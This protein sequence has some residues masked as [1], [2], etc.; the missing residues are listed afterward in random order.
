MSYD[1]DSGR[2]MIPTLVQHCQRGYE[3]LGEGLREEILLPILTSCTPDTLWRFEEEDPVRGLSVHALS[4]HSGSICTDIWKALCH[5]QHPLLVRDLDE[6]G[7]ESWK[8]EYARCHEESANKLEQAAARLRAK[9]QLD[10]EQ[11]KASSIKITDKVPP[12][13]RARWG[14]TT[15]KTLFQ[16]TRTEAVKH[17]KGVFS[18][19]MT[20]PTFQ[21]RALV[22]NATSAWGAAAHFPLP[23]SNSTSTP[24]AS[25]S[26]VTVRAV[27]VPRKAPDADRAPSALSK[28]AGPS[29]PIPTVSSSSMYAPPTPASV[30]RPPGIPPSQ[31]A[32]IRSPPSRSPRKKD[33]SSALF[34]PKH[35]AYS[36]LQAR[37][38]PSKS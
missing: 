33:P 7:S 32:D 29:K 25:G 23:S 34:M 12:T 30:A 35:R 15:S 18:T 8:E 6:S 38:V 16:K 2:R 21:R 24:A 9:R 14:V 11:R 22:N 5:K 28:V 20:R 1:Y 10:E 3:K 13:K 31:P 27:A 36:Q 19:R 26:R 4:L 17:Q 37:G